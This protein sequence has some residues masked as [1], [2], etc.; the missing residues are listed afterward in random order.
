MRNS[1]D[2]D[3]EQFRLAGSSMA[4]Q[5]G[6]PKIILTEALS[7]LRALCTM[8]S[9]AWTDLVALSEDRGPAG[10]LRLLRWE[11]ANADGKRGAAQRLA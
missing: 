11:D 10:R 6:L 9:P 1:N 4:Y 7:A 3:A 2:T 8:P 5:I